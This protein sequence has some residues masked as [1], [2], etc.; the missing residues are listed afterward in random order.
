ML[1]RS[2]RHCVSII[3]AIATIILISLGFMHGASARE[4]LAT[5]MRVGGDTVSTRFV[6]D[7][8]GRAA[9]EV[10]PAADSLQI[11][12]LLPQLKFK[13]GGRIS[14]LKRGLISS[15]RYG[16]TTEGTGRIVI[17]FTQPTQIASRQF[18]DSKSGQPARLVFDFVPAGIEEAPPASLG[19]E[20]QA[21]PDTRRT[22][23]IDP[24][25]GG[26]D[27]GASS[28]N[29]HRE[30]DIVFAFAKELQGQLSKDGG[31]NVVLTRNGDTFVSLQDRVKIAQAAGADLLIALHADV[32]RGRTARGTILYT[33]SEK[34]SDEEAEIFAQ[35]ENK[36]DAIAGLEL[37]AESESANNA[38]FDLVQRESKGEAV[39]F[40]ERVVAE[41]AKVNPV[42]SKPLRSAGF[43]VLKA[44]DVPSVL[45]EL[46]FLSS[47]QDEKLLTS[48]TW[49]QDMALAFRRAIDLHFIE[50][51][52]L[53]TSPVRQ[54]ATSPPQ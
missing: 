49:R 36:T 34:A 10:R 15:V 12:L 1:C 42:T 18:I 48:E 45:V 8:T 38:L 17:A 28:V 30:K 46:G 44:P 22:I 5:G 37:P 32:A 35:K 16:E 52:A 54:P 40:A 4:V 26:L 31:Y 39:L 50:L 53:T 20:P 27:P 47:R 29:N 24:G 2:L 13:I 14:E 7:T 23:V 21:F 6:L 33:L 51:N 3:L 41:I 25:H 9:L 43:V 11:E 19:E